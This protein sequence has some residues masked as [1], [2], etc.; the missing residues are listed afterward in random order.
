MSEKVFLFEIQ[1][2]INTKIETKKNVSAEFHKNNR[3]E[4]DDVMKEILRR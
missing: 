2:F 3:T 1:C 4:D